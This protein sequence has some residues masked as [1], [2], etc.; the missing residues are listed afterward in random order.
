MTPT[1]TARHLGSREHALARALQDRGREVWPLRRRDADLGH[2]V[3]VHRAPLDALTERARWQAAEPVYL[4]GVLGDV[5]GA[6]GAAIHACLEMF[7]RLRSEASEFLDELEAR[8]HDDDWLRYAGSTVD[9][10]DP[11]EVERCFVDAERDGE[12]VARDLW[13]KLAWITEDPSDASLRIR[14]SNGLDQL[15]E[16]MTTSDHTAS[17]VDRFALHAFPECRAVLGCTAL[18]RRLDRLVARPHRLSERIVYNNA[19]N[20]GAAFHHDAE[21]GQLGVV[22]SQL[23]GRTAWFTLSK[24]RLVEL[25]VRFGMGR[26][27]AVRAALDDG[28]DEDLQHVLNRD[29]GFAR[30]L[31]AHGA[32]F[33]LRAG[34]AILLPSHA[35]DQVAWHSVLA[36]GDRPSLAHSYG[37]FGRDD[38]YDVGGDPWLGAQASATRTR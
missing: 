29:E 21:P 26:P 22:F 2:A 32:L 31:A 28:C 13:A 16:W 19:P 30:L 17:W 11:R 34:D 37:V 18:R 25:L 5:A 24:Q 36:L 38:D 9:R 23:E 1:P 15:E 12:P 10:D 6:H 8:L 14:F 3:T 20:G 33:V 7:D 35:F 27:R 4:P